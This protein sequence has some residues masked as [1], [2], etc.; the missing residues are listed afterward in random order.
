MFKI[1]ASSA[2]SGKTFTLAKEYLKLVLGDDPTKGHFQPRYFR[3][4]LAVT[5]TND[6]AHEMKKR[7]L[8][9]LQGFA[10]FDSLESGPQKKLLPLREAVRSELN[11]T[12]AELKS[13]A[14]RTFQAIL[15]GYS[16]FAV[17][18]IDSFVQRVVR[19]FAEE[20]ELPFNFEVNLDQDVLLD[21]AAEQLLAK[22][23]RE[24]Y[25]HLSQLLE[26]FALEKVENGQNWNQLSADLAAFAKDLLAERS[27]EHLEPLSQFS[28]AEF[29]RLRAQLQG[30]NQ[31]ITAQIQDWAA[32]ACDCI[33]SQPDLT[34][35]D[36]FYGKSGVGIYFENWRTG[37]QPFTKAPNSYVRKALEEDT[38]Y[39]NTAKKPVR[40][41]IDAIKT[42]LHECLSAMEQLRRA[43]LGRYVL[44]EQI[45]RHFHKLALLS[46][47][48]AEIAEIQKESGQVHISD[49]NKSIRRVV[50]GEPVPFI[51]ERLGDRYHHLLIDEFQDTSVMQWTNFLPLIENALSSGY[52]NLVVGD[53]KQAIYAWRGGEMQQLVHLHKRNLDELTPKKTR[54]DPDGWV[55]DRYQSIA[56]SIQPESL[57]V[58]YRSCR[59][60]VQFNN[61]LF[62]KLLDV[63]GNEYPLMRQVY[64]EQFHQESPA[65]ARAGGHVQLDFL[66]SSDSKTDDECMLDEVLNRIRE[67][68]TAGYARRDIAV[69]N[70]SNAN[71]KRT[72]NFLK[73][74]GYDIVSTDSLLLAFSEGVNLVVAVLKVIQAPDNRL[75]RYE[76]LY[77]FHRIVL[78]A[79][80][81][82]AANATF[83]PLVEAAS[84]EGFYEYLAQ[85]GSELNAFR[86]RRAGLYELAEKLIGTFRLFERPVETPYLFRFLDVV[87]Q[88]GGNR[89]GHLS[90]FLQFWEQ[91][92]DSLS[93][94][95]PADRDAITITSVHKSKGLEYPVVIVPY[96]HWS[97]QPGRDATHWADLEELGY[98]ELRVAGTDGTERVLRTSSVTLSKVLMDTD[99]R[100]QYEREAEKT[101]IENLNMLYVALTRPTDRLYLLVRMKKPD[102][103]R[104]RAGVGY[105]LY[106]YLQQ[107][108]TWQD[109]QTRYVL[110]E[111]QPKPLNTDHPTSN[112]QH[113]I[114]VPVVISHDRT[115]GLRLRRQAERIFD[116]DTFEKSGDLPRKMRAALAKLK[117]PADLDDSLATLRREGVLDAADV[118]TLKT[119][120]HFLMNR[121][122]IRPWFADGQR[123]ENERELL[124]ATETVCPDRV[125][126]RRDGGVTVVNYEK[127]TLEYRHRER[128]KKYGSLYRQMGY[129]SVETYLLYLDT[130]QVVAVD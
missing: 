80:P 4:V 36:F 100:E 74:H 110:H 99:L 108:G 21:G 101:F 97:T 124:T 42:D 35:L 121:D 40:A 109:G 29:A 38:W 12:E 102:D 88:F 6:A 44:Y 53:G 3:H 23:G 7:I 119:S 67:A 63:Q 27:E 103:H 107:T 5:F 78:G 72:A 2:G 83:R 66:E 76:A 30:F 26:E 115:S 31:Q 73:E 10:E 9:A 32:R 84:P 77:L 46:Q 93:I 25:A 16:D 64:D 122:E 86:L 123:I 113:R 106:Q 57:R 50:L 45:L 114:H 111:G 75:A 48:K 92:K 85:H 128:V 56:R 28:P 19:A 69:L 11:L 24:E 14:E 126:F 52:F 1:Y 89:V 98:E 49:F 39:S 59:E 68:E 8:D 87:L 70:R 94:T 118:Q 47:L 79:V 17:S 20:L 22:A 90:D 33:A 112:I 91:K 62:G 60:V 104:F 51:Y 129:L 61:D 13:R 96:C 120:L 117:T 82:G 18:T 81:D 37:T 55:A 43:A 127:G 54:H 41:F 58:N 15:H 95:T 125:V 34:L 105:L 130:A 65:F 71:S 116:L